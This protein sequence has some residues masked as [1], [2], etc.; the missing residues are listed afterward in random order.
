MPPVVKLLKKFPNIIWDYK[1]RYCVHKNPPL[2]HILSHIS[3]V[4]TTSFHLSIIY[5]NI[6]QL[7]RF[8]RF[9]GSHSAQTIDSSI[10]FCRILIYMQSVPTLSAIAVKSY[11]KAYRT[12]LTSTLLYFIGSELSCDLGN[13]TYKLNFKNLFTFTTITYCIW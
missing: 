10:F 13:V 7:L 5:F 2:I 11:R 9:W 3:P 1:V 8:G 12:V 6:I 4:H